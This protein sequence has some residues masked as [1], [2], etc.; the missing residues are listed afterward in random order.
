MLLQSPIDELHC[1]S[2]R[3]SQVCDCWAG[4]AF[5]S[6]LEDLVETTT[7]SDCEQVR[8]AGV[9]LLFLPSSTLLRR[10]LSDSTCCSAT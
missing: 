8:Y 1:P 6:L 5:L 3:L 10:P 2:S 9:L 4:G 7:I